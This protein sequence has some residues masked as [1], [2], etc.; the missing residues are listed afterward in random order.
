MTSRAVGPQ[1]TAGAASPAYDSA[2]TGQRHTSRDQAEFARLYKQVYPGMVSFGRRYLAPHDAED[3]A[4]EIL[5]G[6]WVRWDLFPAEARVERFFLS[7]MHR[8]VMSEQRARYA[9]RAALDVDTLRSLANERSPDP[10]AEVESWELASAIERGVVAMPEARRKVWRLI[11]DDGLSYAQAAQALGVSQNTIRKQMSRALS[12]LRD[13]LERAGYAPAG[14]GPGRR[15]TS[16]TA[17]DILEPR[18]D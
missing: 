12:G 9:E 5:S 18:E 13:V 4:Q 3:I 11:R 2:A 16:E 15:A 6:V 17:K 14:A 7:A 8:R 1:E 10:V